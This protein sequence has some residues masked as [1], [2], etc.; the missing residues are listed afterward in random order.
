MK[1]SNMKRPTVFS[2][3]SYQQ[4]LDAIEDLIFVKG[5][6]SQLLW[7]NKAFCKYY[8]L[9]L[10]QIEGIL[11]ADFEDPDLTQ[12]YVI[13]DQ[14]VFKTGKTLNI[15]HEAIMKHDGTVSVFHTVK[16]PIFDDKKNVVMSVGLSRNIQDQLETQD[17]LKRNER[18]L[19]AILEN[20]PAVVYA[21]DL[22]G[23]YIMINKQYENIF[24]FKRE[25]TVGKTDY[26]LFGPE[27]AEAFAKNDKK[28]ALSG[29]D[30][31]YEE[32]APMKDGIHTY[33]SCKFPL[34][35]EHG[36]VYGVCGISTDVTERIRIRQQ[37]EEEKARGLAQERLASLG[38]M[39]G[40]IAH[41]INTP[42]AALKTLCSQ[43]T[44]LSNDESLDLAAIKEISALM[45]KTTDRIAS[46]IKN[47]RSVSRDGSK[48][49]Y[50][51][52][53][54]KDLIGD[55][56]SL[57]RTKFIEEDVDIRV[58]VTTNILLEARSVEISQVLLNLLNN[59][60]D[61]I[62][63]YAKKW[64]EISAVDSGDTVEIHVVDC[65]TGI[66]RIEEQKIFQPFYTT[67]EIGKGTGL[68]LSISRRIIEQHGGRLFVDHSS[69]NTKFTIILPKHQ[70]K[71]QKIS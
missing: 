26:E 16:S 51:E 41:E 56:L 46:V 62:G 59:A 8:N 71:I 2:E 60:V 54:L 66:N 40:G 32:Y 68:G 45:D 55:S 42:L 12:Q 28:V 57:C 39:A 9:T 1:N 48:D 31:Q 70:S 22:E 36:A 47:L 38:E 19:H 44:E 61:A 58:N 69:H 11:A 27:F 23:R 33:I 4:I 64:I 50:A 17:K 65:G 67:K 25:E 52:F 18:F 24:N 34:R 53:N 7:A 15:P 43:L 30:I 13:D 10:E 5:P 37:L 29:Q 21:K 63:S 20:T 35:D 3:K 14:K 49:P 6:Q